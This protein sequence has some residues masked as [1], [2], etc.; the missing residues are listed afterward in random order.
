MRM[1]QTPTLCSTLSLL[2]LYLGVS[3]SPLLRAAPT[4]HLLLKT[5]PRIY[6]SFKH[7]YLFLG[8][9]KEIQLVLKQ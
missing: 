8:T 4:S 9:L 1:L 3:P 7:F 6:N 5:S 2:A